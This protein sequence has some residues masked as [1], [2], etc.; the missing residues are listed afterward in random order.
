MYSCQE[1]IGGLHTIST[2]FDPSDAEFYEI[3]SWSLKSLQRQEDIPDNRV[4][5]EVLA[6]V[7]ST[8][9]VRKAFAPSV[10]PASANITGTTEL[11]DKI[12]LNS[13][14]R[15]HR[16]KDFPADG[17]FLEPNEAFV[18][19]AAGCPVITAV[20]GRYMIVTHASRDSLIDRGAVVGEPTRKHVSVVHSIIDAFKER[21]VPA[22]YVEMCM[23]FSIPTEVF[24]HDFNHPQYGRYNRQLG[25]F[26]DGLWPDC[27]VRKNGGLL[28]NLEH[29]FMQ[30][31]A[32]AHIA[33]ARTAERLDG[34]P[35]LA[36]THDGE[37]PSRRNLFIV[38][39]HV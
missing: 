34:H 7:L 14:I 1:R 11:K 26:V 28:L 38:K 15:L 5:S 39:R 17:I 12:F 36:H 29:V 6:H 18:M 25:E 8:I 31:A 23:Q 13:G 20:G 22:K 27:T 2:V 9:G 3:P 21:G 19:S 33:S 37:D 32:R 10:A 35:Y 16:N 24:E 4:F 30:Q